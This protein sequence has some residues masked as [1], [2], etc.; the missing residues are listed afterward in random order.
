MTM[1][2]FNL[3]GQ[4]VVYVMDAYCGWCWGFSQ[5]MK[6]F[7]EANRHRVAFTAISGGLFLGERAAAMAHYPHIA[8]ANERISEMT[9]AIFGEPYQALLQEG[10]RVMDS[11]GAAEGLAALRAQAPERAIHFAHALQ[12][13]FY[14]QGLSLSEPT[15]IAGIACANGLDEAAVLRDLTGGAATAQA[16]A[17]FA[18]ARQLGVASY[19]TLLYVNAGR[20]YP[21]PATGTAL[22]VLNQHLD[23][24]LAESM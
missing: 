16:H 22:S 10:K 3:P 4:A 1:K 19:P 15:T 9:G 21:L 18:L 13:A 11:Q 12:A 17:D 20:I 6:E 8:Q 7:E 24:L 14:G 5:R 2:T 23:V